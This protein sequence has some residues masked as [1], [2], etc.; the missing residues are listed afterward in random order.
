MASTEVTAYSLAVRIT[1]ELL[2]DPGGGPVGIG[3]DGGPCR[4]GHDA[5][6]DVDRNCRKTHRTGGGNTWLQSALGVDLD[7]KHRLRHAG[8]GSNLTYFIFVRT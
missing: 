3:R 6:T 4:I 5:Q 2:A 7:L 1:G 8:R